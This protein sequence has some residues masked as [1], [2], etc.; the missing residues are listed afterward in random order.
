MGFS[1]TGRRPQTHTHTQTQR[2][3]DT[4]TQRH[5]HTQRDTHTHTQRDTHT[6]TKRHTHTRNRPNQDSVFV[7]QTKRQQAPTRK[8]KLVLAQRATLRRG[9]C[10]L[11]WWWK[12]EGT[13]FS[14]GLKRM[15]TKR[16]PRDEN[17]HTCKSFRSHKSATTPPESGVA[18]AK[19]AWESTNQS[20]D[21][22]VCVCV[23]VCLFTCLGYHH[24]VHPNPFDTY[25][26]LERNRL[27]GSNWTGTRINI[28][29]AGWQPGFHR[30][31]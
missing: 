17:C 28:I 27:P 25:P 13:P 22:C 7:G 9:A 3:R 16:M 26:C 21:Q 2:H 5:T 23:R 12:A 14:Q 8:Q 4:E 19:T 11:V 29:H 24:S 18:L 31:S 20:R 10:A 6:H 15:P 30:L 1:E